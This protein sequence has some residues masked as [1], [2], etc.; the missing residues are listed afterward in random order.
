MYHSTQRAG[1]SVRA[2]PGVMTVLGG[3]RREQ[4]WPGSVPGESGSAPGIR[5]AVDRGE[6]SGRAPPAHDAQPTPSVPGCGD[7][8][9]ERQPRLAGCSSVLGC[10]GERLQPALSAHRR[11]MVAAAAAPAGRDLPARRSPLAGGG[12]AAASGVPPGGLGRP[13]APPP[14]VSPSASRSCRPLPRPGSG[15]GP[16]LPQEGARE[17]L[18]QGH[19]Q[20][21]GRADLSAVAYEA[22]DRPLQRV[23]E[24][25]GPGRHSGP[26]CDGRQGPAAR[27]ITWT[28][29]RDAGVESRGPRR[30]P[31][32]T[33]G[34]ET[35]ECQAAD[36]GP[37]ARS[38][39]QAAPRPW[40][41]W[42][43]AVQ[44]GSV[45][46]RR[47]LPGSFT[48]RNVKTRSRRWSRRPQ[49]EPL[50]SCC[51]ARPSPGAG[52]CKVRGGLSS[53]PLICLRGLDS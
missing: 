35:E 44:P 49:A 31:S 33:K 21:G 50:R 52:L 13:A 6:R 12:G 30:S 17:G 4:A 32:W 25:L 51:L 43:L 10:P 23:P 41:G 14:P 29:M 42:A 7:C 15:Q 46:Y 9:R 24:G 18:A 20:R 48:A 34:Q 22:A 8:V 16:H 3:G 27:D 11:E 37:A 38:T 45:L 19:Q 28:G 47:L 39:K 2:R 36:V 5:R 26:A 53:T 40:R 1:D